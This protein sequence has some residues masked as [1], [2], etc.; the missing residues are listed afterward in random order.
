ME[1]YC[2]LGYIRHAHAVLCAVR[3]DWMGDSKQLQ[4]RTLPGCWGKVQEERRSAAFLCRYTTSVNLRPNPNFMP[5]FWTFV[6]MCVFVD[7]RE[8][9]VPRRRP[10]QDGAVPVYGRFVP[11]VLF[12]RFWC[13]KAE[14]RGSYWNHT[15]AASLQ[16]LCQGP[17]SYATL[18]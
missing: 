12:L 16:G 9:R 7:S 18:Y 5:K 10:G 13:D 2:C 6:C 17:L 15:S 11:E 1:A 4:P 3:Q 8:A 14:Y